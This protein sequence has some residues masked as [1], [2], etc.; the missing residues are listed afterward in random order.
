MTQQQK[1][2]LKRITGH[3]LEQI[4]A[5]NGV[6]FYYKITRLMC[7]KKLSSAQYRWLEGKRNGEVVQEILDIFGGEIVREQRV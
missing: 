3:S 5:M 6:D 1:E 4:I 2:N 7:K